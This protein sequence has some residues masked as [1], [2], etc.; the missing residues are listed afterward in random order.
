ML[1]DRF[2]S[3][4]QRA[5]RA[6]PSS[7]S[8]VVPPSLL[9][10]A[11]IN[12]FTFGVD[13]VLVTLA[14][15][16]LGW[17]VPVAITIGYGTAFTLSYLLNRVLNFRSH[18]PAG[19]ESARYA[20]VVALNFLVLLL[21]VGSGLAALGVPYQLARLVAGACEGAFMYCAM[22]W[23]VFGAARRDDAERDSFTKRVG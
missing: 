5:S 4:M 10:F 21:G 3:A 20:A 22:R 12:G 11:V 8:R 2:A 13:L 6:L 16:A 9:G 17:P 1:A 19:P 15:G 14:H 23:F 18:A 7:I